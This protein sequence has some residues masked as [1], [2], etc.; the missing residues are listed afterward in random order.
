MIDIFN[1]RPDFTKYQKTIGI[2]EKKPQDEWDSPLYGGS[3]LNYQNPI[4]PDLE[5]LKLSENGV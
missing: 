4:L 5:L 2:Y 3:I 1:S